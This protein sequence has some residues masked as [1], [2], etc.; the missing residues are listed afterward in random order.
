MPMLSLVSKKQLELQLNSLLELEKKCV[1]HK[2]FKET[3]EANFYTFSILR[4][5]TTESGHAMLA[6]ANSNNVYAIHTPEY[7]TEK[8][9]AVFEFLLRDAEPHEKII[10]FSQKSY[11]AVK[12]YSYGKSL[13]VTLYV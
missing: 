10:V 13:N 2:I 9:M 3:E 7:L 1:E 4:D 5:Y 6:V 12:K 11:D 8:Q